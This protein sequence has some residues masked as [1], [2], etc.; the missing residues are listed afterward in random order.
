MK[1]LLLLFIIICCLFSVACSKR[2]NYA[3]A[4]IYDNDL[5]GLFSCYTSMSLDALEGYRYGVHGGVVDLNM[6]FPVKTELK[7]DK[8]TKTLEVLVI[9]DLTK[10]AF[11]FIEATENSVGVKV[12]YYKFKYSTQIKDDKTYLH[13]NL[14]SENSYEVLNNGKQS[15]ITNTFGYSITPFTQGCDRYYEYQIN[16]NGNLIIANDKYWLTNPVY[17]REK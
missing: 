9:F 14:I 17:Y 5:D 1:K 8:H 13:C 3:Y 6:S 2:N 12:F 11:T 7:F 15:T 4:P 16:K 10:N